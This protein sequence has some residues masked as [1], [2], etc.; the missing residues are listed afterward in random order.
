MYILTNISIHKINLI[1]IMN[2]KL[3][4]TADD[5]I[6]HVEKKDIVAINI[7]GGML[8]KFDSVYHAAAVKKNLIISSDCS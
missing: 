6:H 5:I 3:I 7:R 1:F 4:V 2:K 8:I